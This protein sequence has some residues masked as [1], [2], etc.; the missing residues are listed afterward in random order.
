MNYTILDCYT[1]E[2]AG[3]GVP[4]YLGTYPRYIYGLLKS[5]GLSPNY[6]TIDDLRLNK[7]YHNII[8]PV[9]DK[10]K[11]NI[12]I[13]NLTRENITKILEETEVLIINLGVHVPGKYLSAVPGTIREIIP[14]IQGMRCRKILT[15]PAIFGTQLEGGKY[16]EKNDMAVFDEV[17]NFGF[18]FGGFENLQRYAIEGAELVRQIPY[19][20]IIEIETGRGCNVGR[21]SFCTEPLKNKFLNRKTDDI[22]EEVKRFYDLGCRNFRLGKQ[23]DFYSIE[24]P[25]RLLREIREKCPDIEVLHIDNVNPV[26]VINERG[27]EITKAIVK[28]CTE[29]NIAAFGIESFDP[30]VVKENTLNCT[31]AIAFKALQILNELGSERGKNGMPK[32]LPGI[33]IIYG[34]GFESKK[35]HEYNMEALKKIYDNG[36]MLR[37]INIRQ[38]AILPG[39]MMEKKFGMKYFIKNKK[40]YWKWRNDIRQNIDFP[41]LKRLVPE[42][43]IMRDVYSEIYDGKTTFARQIGTYPLIIGIKERLPLKKFYDVKITSHMLRSVTGVVVDEGRSLV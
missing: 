34:L 41:M 32:F 40:Y 14:L 5:K 9:T 22:I 4:P 38:A 20:L 36:W 30:V 26:F 8:K 27:I 33:N 17:K 43:T 12:N 28:Y 24:D 21:C 19:Y 18:E 2:A 35:T 37:R 23:A 42:G 25:I 11:T 7:I 10:D 1:D 6:I 13:Y 3:L 16:F 15:G 39:T 29:G 31:P